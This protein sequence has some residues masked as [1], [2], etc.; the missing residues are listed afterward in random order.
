MNTAAILAE[1]GKL[2]VD[3]QVVLVQRIWDNIAQTESPLA[4]SDVQKAELDRRSAELDADP[5]IGVPWEDAKRSL[6]QRH[7]R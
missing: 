5:E 4:L 6:E 1:I 2:P 7:N 3:E